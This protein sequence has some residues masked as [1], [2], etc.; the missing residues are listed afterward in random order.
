MPVHPTI[1]FDLDGTLADTAGDLMGA[2]NWVLRRDAIAPLPV[3][4][5]RSLL[6]AGGRALIRRGYAAAGHA[7]SE[8][9]LEE[10]FRDFLAYY[11]AHIVDHSALFPG[12]LEA[13][14]RLAA[15]GCGLAVCTNKMEHAARKL[16]RELGV[17]ERFRAIC[18]QDTF[19]QSKP[20]AR[21]LTGTIALAGGE[22][23][24]A[25]MVGDSITDIAT[26]RAA[27]VP[28]VAV[29]FGYTDRPVAE[30]D[31]DLVISHFDDLFEAVGA[32]LAAGSPTLTSG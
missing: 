1:V 24:R 3:G 14:D 4:Q 29:D 12:A 19:A 10:V 20:D 8:K 9:R 30:L 13:L 31:P 27:G 28:V 17:G 25:V 11:E 7:L 2:L 23:A 15:R 26:A 22:A 6:G 18:G 5:A 32:L 21:A 16:L